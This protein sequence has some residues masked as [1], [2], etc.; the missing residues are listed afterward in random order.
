MSAFQPR[1]KGYTLSRGREDRD[2]ARAEHVSPHPAG[3]RFDPEFRTAARCQKCG[4]FCY[5]PRHLLREA[6]LEHWQTV[7]PARHTR[8]DQVNEA[9]ILYP[10]Q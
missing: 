5:G 7:C 2:A 6:L 10:K 3:E 1:P 9:R 4:K 8:A